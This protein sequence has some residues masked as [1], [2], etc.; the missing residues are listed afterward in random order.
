M[1]FAAVG[2]SICGKCK[3]KSV[4]NK[5]MVQPRAVSRRH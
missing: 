4:V 5:D 3:E 1:A 2:V